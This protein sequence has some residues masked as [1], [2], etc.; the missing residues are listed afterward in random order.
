MQ[1]QA[2]IVALAYSKLKD[3]EFLLANDRFDNAY[4]LAGYAVELLLKARVCKT[5]GISDF[6]D[7]GNSTKKKLK[8]E[9][10]LTKPFKVHDL[11]QLFILS[12]IYTHFEEAL[13]TNALFSDRWAI[14]LEW[15]ENARY[16]TGKSF[17]DVKDFLTSVKEVMVWI[18]KHL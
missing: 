12:G 5:L 6:F 17:G 16:L 3:A 2:D 7:F 18:Q 8:N 10:N 4:Y 14:V 11:E 9:A 1:S 15:N 13:A